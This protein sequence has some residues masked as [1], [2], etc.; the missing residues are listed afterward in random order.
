M[1]FQNNDPTIDL[2]DSSIRLFYLQNGTAIFM[3]NGTSPEGV[4]F[5][6]VGSIK[7]GSD[8]KMW[9]KT[10][11]LSLSTGWQQVGTFA[12]GLGFEKIVVADTSSTTTVGTGLDNLTSIVIPGNTW[13]VGQRINY[14]ADG[15]YNGAGGT[16]RLV[17]VGGAATVLDTGLLAIN[18]SNWHLE[19]QLLR[20]SA[21]LLCTVRLSFNGFGATDVTV[22]R[23]AT[24]FQTPVFANPYTIQIQAECANAGDT[25]TQGTAIASLL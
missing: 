1:P 19:A 6:G 20:V 11:G 25:V 18:N 21:G 7:F 12:A 22:W 24:A 9:L 17:L 10:S 3:G 16:K 2:G 8:G 4:I 15:N 13:A 23:G 14:V 5:A